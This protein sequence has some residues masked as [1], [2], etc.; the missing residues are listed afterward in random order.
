M[1]QIAQLFDDT[2]MKKRPVEAIR[3]DV[4]DLASQFPLRA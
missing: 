2:L 3:Q 4:A 1:K